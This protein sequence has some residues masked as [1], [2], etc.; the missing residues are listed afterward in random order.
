L[1]PVKKCNGGK[2]SEL[3]RNLGKGFA[4]RLGFLIEKQLLALGK[5][6]GYS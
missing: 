6:S 3:S 2:I 4:Q 5:N 1:R